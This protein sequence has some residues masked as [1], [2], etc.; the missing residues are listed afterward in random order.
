MGASWIRGLALALALTTW[1]GCGVAPDVQV[2]SEAPEPRPCRAVV[3][4]HGRPIERDVTW[5]DAPHEADRARLDAACRTVGPVV[6]ASPAGEAGPPRGRSGSAGDRRPESPSELVAVS[7]NVHGGA[8]N[9]RALVD[10]I[11]GRADRAA[12]F[13][14]PDSIRVLTHDSRPAVVLLLQE[15]YRAGPRVP[16]GVPPGAPVPRAVRPDVAWREDVVSIARALALHLVYVPSMRNGRAPGPDGPEDRGTAILST[17][18][19]ED[20]AVIELPL[21]RHRRAAVAATMADPQSGVRTRVVSL[22]LDTVGSW[23]RLYLFSSRHRARQAEHVVDVL[24]R[25]GNVVLGA[26]LNT[27]S[28]GP[29][30]SAVTRLRQ[31]FADTPAPRW[32]PTYQGMWRLDYFFFRLPGGWAARV[33]RLPPTF[34]S[35]HHPLV[36]EITVKGRQ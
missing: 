4:G 32:Q 20:V 31:A 1:V 5:H 8:G 33:R 24:G 22:H 23:R 15:A 34:G 21:A 13:P 18:P 36:A 35:D 28:E 27:W 30:E 6:I 12:T 19:L 7:W 2:P 25:A 9:V 29:A 16:A 14:E 11:V 17:M 10:A 3:D 26:D